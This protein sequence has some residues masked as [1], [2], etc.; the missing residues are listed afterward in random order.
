MIHAAY[1]DFIEDELKKLEAYDALRPHGHVYEFHKHVRRVARSMKMLALATD[2]GEE[3][4]ETLYW[5][6][7]AHDAGKRLL[8]VGIWDVGNKPDNETK[9]MR[10]QHTQLGVKIVDDAFGTDCH[11]PFLDLLRDLM[12]NHHEAMDGSGWLKKKGSDLSLEARMLCICDA[13][14]GYSVWRPHYGQRDISPAGVLHRM[15]VE[16]AG[17][18]DDALLGVFSKLKLEKA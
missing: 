12:A 13:F 8:P 6:A 5:A 7:L 1:Q 18:F 17:H 2:L 4:A 16:K 9:R 14:D 10:R 3:L 11:E 15:R